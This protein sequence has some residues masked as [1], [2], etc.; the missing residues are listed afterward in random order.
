MGCTTLPAASTVA[1]PPSTPSKRVIWALLAPRSLSSLAMLLSRLCDPVRGQVYL[2]GID[3]RRLTVRSVRDQTA[4]VLQESVLF[5]TTIAENI[6]Y[7][8]TDPTSDQIRAAAVLAGADGFI[9]RLP[10]GYGTVVGERGA[11]LSGGER[12]RIA[13]ARAAMRRAPIVVL[14]EAMTGLDPRTEAEVHAALHRLTEGCTTVVISHEPA[15]ALACDRAVWIEE[16]RIVN[17]GHPRL[18]LAR[19]VGGTHAAG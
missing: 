14:D 16:G 6:G 1:P 3:L 13:I 4:V 7:G 5:A 18:V 12:Q 19:R 9:S 17:D 10:Q 11:T 2:D 15:A 8:T